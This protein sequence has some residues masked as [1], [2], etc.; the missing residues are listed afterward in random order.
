MIFPSK[1]SCSLLGL[2]IFDPRKDVWFTVPRMTSNIRFVHKW[3]TA[4]LDG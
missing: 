4:R 3:D 2:K 1:T